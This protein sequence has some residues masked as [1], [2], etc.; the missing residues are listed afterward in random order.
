MTQLADMLHTRILSRKHV[1]LRISPKIK[2][3]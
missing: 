1:H 3:R 2:E